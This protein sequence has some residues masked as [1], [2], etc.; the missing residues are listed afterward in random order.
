M[1]ELQKS[2]P[3][4]DFPAA[5]LRI[6][7]MLGHCW[8]QEFTVTQGRH[9]LLQGSKCENKGNKVENNHLEDLSSFE[10]HLYYA[11]SHRNYAAILVTLHI[12]AESSTICAEHVWQDLDIASDLFVS[13]IS[14]HAC[15]S[16]S[17]SPFWSLSLSLLPSSLLSVN[18]AVT[19]ALSAD[20]EVVLQQDNKGDNYLTATCDGDK[21]SLQSL[22]KNAS[23]SSGVCVL[24][25]PPCPKVELT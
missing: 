4:Q 21:R 10:K 3:L 7:S 16:L 24:P 9:A 14:S 15:P 12:L 13:P 6:F 2:Q 11:Y 23:R 18:P 20:T 19:E 1:L 8:S 17:S 25:F 22:L 5:H